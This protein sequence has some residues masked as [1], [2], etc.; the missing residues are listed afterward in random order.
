M[1][2]APAVDVLD[3]RCVQLEGGDPDR[4][5]V[6]LEDPRPV[7]DRWLQFGFDV[8]HVIDL[9]A[10]LGQGDNAELIGEIASRPDADVQVGGG[11][12]S[13]VIA[14]RLLGQG[15]TRVIVG[16]RAVEDPAWLEDLATARPGRV[17]VAA[18]VRDDQV[19]TR[20]WTERSAWPLDDYLERVSG[21]PLA[22]IL[23]T[24]VGREGRLTGIDVEWTRAVVKR[25]RA[26]LWVSGGIESIDD[27]RGAADAGAAGA[28]IGMALY[29][30]RIDA[31]QLAKEFGR[32]TSTT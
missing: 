5:P 9:S 27:L 19:L 8:L 20:G 11:V 2:A 24:D 26:P 23:V 18:D 13:D 30:G 31:A 28:V 12:R 17:M 1:I 10:A 22:G 4:M 15:A 21:L 14:D 25:C 6:A 29:T 3:G 16:T 32:D 7:A